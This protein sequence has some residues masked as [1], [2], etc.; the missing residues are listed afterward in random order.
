[1]VQNRAKYH[2]IYKGFLKGKH[3]SGAV[4]D[5]SLQLFHEGGPYHI[6]TSPL[7]CFANQWTGFYMMGTSAMKVKAAISSFFDPVLHFI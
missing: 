7:N 3:S 2:I 1:M 4:K 5:K 6:E